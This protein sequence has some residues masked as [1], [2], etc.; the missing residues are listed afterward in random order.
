M[1]SKNSSSCN[2]CL[3]WFKVCFLSRSLT[4]YFTTQRTV[5]NDLKTLSYHRYCVSRILPA[6]LPRFVHKRNSKNNFSRA[7]RMLE[8]KNW[9][10]N[11]AAVYLQTLHRFS[12]LLCLSSRHMFAYHSQVTMLRLLIEKQ[13]FEFDKFTRRLFKVHFQR[14]FCHFLG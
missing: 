14:L 4:P 3:F 9:V 6:F 5:C 2:L 8:N 7:N 11:Y 10:S 12:L 13:K 1:S